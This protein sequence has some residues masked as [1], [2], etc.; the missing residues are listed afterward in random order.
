M[1]H[2][3]ENVTSSGAARRGGDIVQLFPPS[4]PR[5]SKPETPSAWETHGP[6]IVLRKMNARRGDGPRVRPHR[7]RSPALRDPVEGSQERDASIWMMC[8]VAFLALALG[9]IF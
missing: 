2:L 3:A 7:A 9:L 1:S 6:P 4:A 5:E 8:A